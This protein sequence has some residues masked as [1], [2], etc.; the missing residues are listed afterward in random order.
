MYFS[1]NKKTTQEDQTENHL[2]KLL[3]MTILYDNFIMSRLSTDSIYFLTCQ[4]IY[5]ASV[6]TKKLSQDQITCTSKFMI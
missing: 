4:R 5:L 2:I 1:N 6:S 3:K